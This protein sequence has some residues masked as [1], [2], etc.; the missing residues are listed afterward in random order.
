[1][2]PALYLYFNFFRVY[3]VVPCFIHLFQQPLA[4]PVD[5]MRPGAFLLGGS[6]M[7]GFFW[8]GPSDGGI[9]SSQFFEKLGC[10]KKKKIN[11]TSTGLLGIFSVSFVE[12][13]G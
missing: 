13:M 8:V 10:R 9:N 7:E 11:Q 5:F 6:L 1:M 12:Y 3:R 4:P 2:H